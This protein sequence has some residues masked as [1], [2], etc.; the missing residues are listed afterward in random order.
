[1]NP[2]LT[3]T[4]S[5]KMSQLKQL[6][7]QVQKMQNPQGYLQ[8]LISQ[9]PKSRDIIDAIRNNNGNLEGAYYELAKKMGQDPDVIL[10]QLK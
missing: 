6:Y 9:N 5:S 4:M 8:Q 2:L 1:M 3:N 10:N 7:N